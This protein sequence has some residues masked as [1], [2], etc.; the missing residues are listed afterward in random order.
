MFSYT[1]HKI[2][3]YRLIFEKI[4][5]KKNFRG[6]SPLY[7][8]NVGVAKMSHFFNRNESVLT[9]KSPGLKIVT[10]LIL[11]MDGI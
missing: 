9:E 7:R 3:R 2:Y 11:N 10:L 4:F 8:E 6:K 1:Y 5:F